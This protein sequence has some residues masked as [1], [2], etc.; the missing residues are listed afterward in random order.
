MATCDD[1]KLEE[2]RRL[3]GLEVDEQ[4]RA[5]GEGGLTTETLRRW[6]IARKGNVKE[7]AKDLRAHAAWRVGF[8]PKGR[9]VTE[10]VQDDI[11][12]NKAFLPGF[13]KSGRPFC[14]VVV[15]RHQ[16]KDAE[17][18]KRF[19][20]YSLDCATLLGSNKP[21]WDGK[22]NG[23]FD[24]RGLKP[25]NC[26]LATLRNVFDLLQHHYPERAKQRSRLV[27]IFLAM[28]VVVVVEWNSPDV[29]IP[30][31]E[32]LPGNAGVGLH[33]LWL[34]NAPYIFY[35]IYKLVYPF[36]DPVTREKVRFVYGKEADAELLAA[37]DPE[38]LPAEICS[39]GTGR[40]VSVQEQYER[41]L[42]QQQQQQGQQT[43]QQQQG[44]QTCQQQQGQ[45]LQVVSSL[46]RGEGD[47]LQYED[48][49]PE[50]LEGP[51]EA[52]ESR[53]PLEVVA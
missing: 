14:I 28:A 12:Q 31:V 15:S 39:R 52:V 22:L 8:V 17:A 10:E 45:Q 36:I 37:F 3:C 42:K 1:V 21:D 11:N 35:G 20:A 29:D 25:S 44:Q 50:P 2:L 33:T 49:E 32:Q 43:C 38:V 27:M 51:L 7:A 41:L 4:L 30:V 24:L 46:S 23:I 6:L 18:S 13:D 53:R 48:C 34:L 16:I 9:V 19:I 40:W 47:G 5:G 26:D